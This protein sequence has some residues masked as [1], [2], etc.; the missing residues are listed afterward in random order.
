MRIHFHL[1]ISLIILQNFESENFIKLNF[2]VTLRR[3]STISV[4]VTSSYR[5]F[6]VL[7][8]IKNVI[9]MTVCQNGLSNLVMLTVETEL[10]TNANLGGIKKLL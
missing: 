9:R 7:K 1:G 3:F 2:N 10:V 5:F 4:T 8:R 6:L